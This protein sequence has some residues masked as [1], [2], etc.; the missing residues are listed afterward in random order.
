MRLLFDHHI[1]SWQ[2]FGGVSKYF[3]KLIEH[4]RAANIECSLPYMF[5]NNYYIQSLTD[6]YSRHWQVKG[7]YFAI[8]SLNKINTL[9]ILRKHKFDI[10][11][12]TSTSNYFSHHIRSKPYVVTAHD[13]TIELFP[14]YFKPWFAKRTVDERKQNYQYASRI[15]AISENTRND[16]VKF[17]QIDPDKIDVIYHGYSFDNGSAER[18]R[19]LATSND[20]LLYVGSRKEYKNFDNFLLACSRVDNSISIVCA[21]GGPFTDAETKAIHQAGMQGRINQYNVN[22]N[23]LAYLYRKARMFVYPSLYEGF[24]MPVLEAF[25]SECPVALSDIPVFREIAGNAAR[26][27]SPYDPDSIQDC[28]ESILNNTSDSETMKKLGAESIQ[29]YRWELTAQKTINTY[30]KVIEQHT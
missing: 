16:L 18:I 21:G 2:Q 10:F 4:L 26:Y 12:P 24:G 8:E 28:I 19:D 15:I 1:F 25:A 14:Q 6:N 23:E 30:K 22:N 9:R 5:T 11:H 13:L 3:V 7:S 29:K 17:Y 20:Y 27:F